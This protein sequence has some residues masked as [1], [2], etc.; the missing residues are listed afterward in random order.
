[1]LTMCNMIFRYFV[2]NE[3]HYEAK[4]KVVKTEDKEEKSQI[5]RTLIAYMLLSKS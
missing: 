1:M 3:L 5:L 2:V 4:R